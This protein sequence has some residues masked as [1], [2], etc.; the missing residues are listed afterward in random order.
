[1]KAR[2]WRGP[3]IGRE[4]GSPDIC[5]GALDEYSIFGSCMYVLYASPL[6]TSRITSDK[7]LVLHLDSQ[8]NEMRSDIMALPWRHGPISRGSQSNALIRRSRPLISSVVQHLV[9]RAPTR[10]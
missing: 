5:T 9:E 8:T 4:V 1:M 2:A 10:P 3:V 6:W 7:R